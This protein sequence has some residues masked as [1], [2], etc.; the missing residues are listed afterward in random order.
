MKK[1]LFFCALLA[2][3]STSC[4]KSDF[5][6]ASSQ[7]DSILEEKQKVVEEMTTYLEIIQDVQANFNSIKSTELGIIEETAGAEGVNAD[8][9][10]KLSSDFQTISEALRANRAQI[11][12]LDSALQK[13]QGN[14]A[15]FRGL[16]SGLKKQLKESESSLKKMQK[17]LADKDLKIE[18]LDNEIK[19]MALT[20]D[21]MSQKINELTASNQAQEATLN[22]AYYFV[23]DK[24]AIKEK[25]L[26]AKLLASASINTS[27]FTQVDIREFKELDLGAKKAI[28]LSSH[29]INSYT[30]TRKSEEDK[31]LVLKI[32]NYSAFWSNTHKL[33]IQ[34]K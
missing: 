20:Q 34:V 6:K 11:A 27:Y 9:K 3:M 5:E 16:V 31:N 17:D 28:V 25:G 33:I 2:L 1:V 15:Y 10:D 21:T 14:A 26:K 7:R 18:S 30:I 12:Q 13:A 23:G 8:T 19:Q 24:T 32:T 29:P 4:Y 22:T